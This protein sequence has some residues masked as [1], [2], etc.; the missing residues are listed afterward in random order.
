MADSPEL[1]FEHFG[2]KGMHWGIRKDSSGGTPTAVETHTAPG[3]KVKASGG[4][5]QPASEDAIR[6]AGHRQKAKASTTDSLSTQELKELVDR[7]NLEQ[8]YS[9]LSAAD[10]SPGQ[11]FVKDF[12]QN[13]G[14]QQAQNYVNKKVGAIIAEKTGV[15]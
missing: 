9:R 7:M 4:H 13:V 15:K 11:K 14:K 10:M 2:I 3:R 8:Q 5:N 1:F 12:V 6:V